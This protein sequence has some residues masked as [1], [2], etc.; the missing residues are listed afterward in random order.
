M[1]EF[2]YNNVKNV[3]T[4]HILFKF[5]YWFYSQVLFEEDV[6][7]YFKSYLANKYIGKLKKLMEMCCQNLFHTQE[8]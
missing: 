5:N 3:K 6:N 4:N 1:A 7:P 8:L 2:A